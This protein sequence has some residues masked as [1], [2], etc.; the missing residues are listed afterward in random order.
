MFFLAGLLSA[1]AVGSK[2]TGLVSVFLPFAIAVVD[3]VKHFS[4]QN[5]KSWL[6][7]AWVFVIAFSFLYLFGWYLHFELLDQPGPGDVW[8]VLNGPFLENV[9]S[10]HKTMLSANANLTA[11]HPDMSLWWGW[12]W[13]H[14]PLFYW[15]D[16]GKVIYMM[17]NPLTWWGNTLFL[18]TFSLIAL[19]LK[20]SSLQLPVLENSN[21]AP[22]YG[23]I[24][25]AYLVS[26][27][28]LI[29]VSRALFLYHYFTPFIFSL[30]FVCLWL[31]RIGWLQEQSIFKQRYSVYLVILLVVTSFYFILPL[32]YGLV[33]SSVRADMIFS[34]FPTWR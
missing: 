10:I 2:F 25:V 16:T 1:L 21:T 19:M 12:P 22:R 14:S 20:I 4:W 26:F 33:D 24:F 34:V 15:V 23:L 32:T 13:M 27:V 6:L 9:I 18:I 3:C 17:G 30:I 31:Q 8:G 11:T 5:I 29:L 7:A 28:P